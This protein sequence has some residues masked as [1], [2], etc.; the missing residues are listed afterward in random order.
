MKIFKFIL[1]FFLLAAPII[2]MAAQ[3]EEIPPGDVKWNDSEDPNR[4]LSRTPSLFKDANFV[5]V[6]FFKFFT[7]LSLND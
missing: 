1:T 3:K 4:S 5:Y 6:Y 2:T 7:L